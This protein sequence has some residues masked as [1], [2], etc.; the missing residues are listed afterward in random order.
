MSKLAT[1]TDQEG[2]KR[3]FFYCPGCKQYHMFDSRWQFNG[4]MDKPTFSP[5]L[6][7]NPNWN[8]RR[9]HL[10]VTDGRI[11]FLSDCHHDLA[12]QTVDMAE[13]SIGA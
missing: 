11:Q 2:S 9:C 4:D 6:L 10:Y 12:G 5:S 1:G 3:Y 13:E 8:E 7:C